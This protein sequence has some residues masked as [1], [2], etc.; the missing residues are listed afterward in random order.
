MQLK[1]SLNEGLLTLDEEIL[2]L[3]PNDDIEMEIEQADT[4]KEQIHQSHRTQN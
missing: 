3:I 4:F 1:L 2:K